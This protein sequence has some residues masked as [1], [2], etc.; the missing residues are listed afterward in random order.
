MFPLK[1]L[2]RFFWRF[3]LAYTLGRGL[4]TA[5]WPGWED[6]ST[7][8]LRAVARTV[9]A[10]SSG[11]REI[12]FEPFHQPGSRADTRIVIVNRGL[13]QADGSGP[14]R[15]LDLNLGHSELSAIA[16]LVALLVA[17]P[18]SWRRRGWSLLIGL[19]ALQTCLLGILSLHIWRESAEVLL[20][21]LSP[22][23]KALTSVLQAASTEQSQIALPVLIWFFLCFRSENFRRWFAQSQTQPRDHG[24][25]SILALDRPVK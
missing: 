24:S 8:F 21:T 14:V 7:S 3:A 22:S 2:L 10:T 25:D 1:T 20:V 19:I 18:L 13:M 9:L 6:A 12:S 17:T 5:P 11:S 23:L 16:L 4:L 15:N